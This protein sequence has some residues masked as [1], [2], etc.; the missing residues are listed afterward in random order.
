M[1]TIRE[2]QVLETKLYVMKLELKQPV[3]ANK[4]FNVIKI[5]D[6]TSCSHTQ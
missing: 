2:K 5:L 6:N 4:T 1:A 3:V